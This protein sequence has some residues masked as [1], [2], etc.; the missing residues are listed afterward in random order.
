MNT[1][2]NNFFLLLAILFFM[3]LTNHSTAS[4]EALPPWQRTTEQPPA[5]KANTKHCVKV[6]AYAKTPNNMAAYAQIRDQ[7]IKS[8][9]IKKGLIISHENTPEIYERLSFG[10]GFGPGLILIKTH[11]GREAFTHKTYSIDSGCQ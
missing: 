2:K 11:D 3:I 1:A 4:E 10:D 5:I 9:M 7:E 8:L 6:M